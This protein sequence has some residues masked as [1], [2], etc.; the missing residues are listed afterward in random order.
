MSPEQARG[1][2]VD[3]RSDVFGVGILLY[4]CL[5]GTNPFRV[6]GSTRL[7]HEWRT[8]PIS[9]IPSNLWAVI[10]RALAERPEDR[11]SSAS[12]LADALRAS[13]LVSLGGSLSTTE[14]LQRLRNTSCEPRRASQIGVR[15]HVPRMNR[16]HGATRSRVRKSE[17]P[18]ALHVVAPI[19]KTERATPEP[20]AVPKRVRASVARSWVFGVI[21]LVVAGVVNLLVASTAVVWIA[22]FA[23]IATL[24]GLTATTR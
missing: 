6:E 24:T 23:V 20:V 14:R 11:F 3:A 4:E 1:E 9:T 7:T 13:R 17:R 16:Q 2:E 5:S 22:T 8:V 18:A 19:A 12:E 15:A 21:A 10:A